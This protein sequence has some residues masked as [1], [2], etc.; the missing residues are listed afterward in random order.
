MKLLTRATVRMLAVPIAVV[1]TLGVGVV[2]PTAATAGTGSAVTV[3]S[4][5]A[6]EAMVDAAVQAVENGEVT[7]NAP[8]SA[9]KPSE[10]DVYTIESDEGAFTSVT[11]PVGG[12]Y[13]ML[14]NLTVVFDD[15]ENI[16]QHTETLIG[17]ND[18]GNFNVTSYLDGGLVSSQDTD[19]PYMTDAELLEDLES[20]GWAPGASP[21]EAQSTGSCLAAVLGVSGV[22]G[23]IIAYTCAGACAAAAAGVGVPFCVACIAAYA[24]I[25]GA[26]ITAV[27]SCF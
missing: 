9:L 5:D 6:A 25:G 2:A 16:A 22:V 7:V 14:S 19:L 21:I 23:A 17:Q 18:A 12:S 11:V 24:T 1:M 4:G 20:T 26:S 8:Q 10:A 3:V 27:A 15:S 13:S